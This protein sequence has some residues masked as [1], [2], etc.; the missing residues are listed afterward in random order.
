M[1]KLEARMSCHICRTTETAIS[2]I[3]LAAP[4]CRAIVRRRREHREGGSSPSLAPSVRGA[5]AFV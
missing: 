2:Y 3:P 1:I 4:S 5:A